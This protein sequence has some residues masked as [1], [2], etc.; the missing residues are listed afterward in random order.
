M[1]KLS[2]IIP[3]RNEGEKLEQV[4]KEVF[5]L[6]PYEVITVI[7]G[8]TDR[9]REIAEAHDC[10]VLYY[11]NPLGH[12]IGRAI[13]AYFSKGDILLFMDGDM[14]IPYQDLIPF[15]ETMEDGADIALNNLE[16]LLMEPHRPHSISI[17]KKALNE[18]YEAPELT[19]NSLV[20]IP[21]SISRDALKKIG[22]HN[23]AIPPLAQGKA[24]KEQLDIITPKYLDVI[25]LNKVRP[26]L[27]LN[28][29]T[30]TPYVPLE[31]IIIGD[32]L[33]A[34]HYLIKLKGERAGFADYRDREFINQFK[35]HKKKRQK[36]KS[37]II[38]D[39][40]NAP[41][42]Q[43]SMH[44]QRLKEADS[45]EIIV[46]TYD[47]DKEKSSALLLEGA[48]VIPLN[49]S[50][51]PCITRSIGAFYSSGEVVLFTDPLQA[52]SKEDYQMIFK[53]LDAGADIALID[54]S[55]SLDDN[56]IGLQCTMH[57][58][59]NILLSQPTLWNN[60]IYSFPHAIRRTVIN[61][62]GYDSLA[63]PPLAQTKAFM[64]HYK[65]IPIQTSV[66]KTALPDNKE[67]E[68]FIGDHVEAIAWFLSKTNERGAFSAGGKNYKAVHEL[69]K[70]TPQASSFMSMIKTFFKFNE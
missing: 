18:M 62:I 67:N 36:K 43:I 32:H 50:L 35:T 53:E 6:H 49:K 4:L 34:I 55:A 54:Q 27:H 21:H 59:L 42:T 29:S 31:N 16:G 47:E 2:V 56:P 33:S 37:A 58:L 10:V 28:I 5:M 3:V 52:F 61:D 1:S 20:A 15:I 40:N 8:S 9:S 38:C 57:Y 45:D 7:N 25:A 24:I 65:L 69:V 17:L 48:Y 60:S 41:L 13:G 64:N 63:I 11:E 44:I 19:I 30:D 23:L 68:V 46:V 39:E 22:W 14:V 66:K 12:D 51:G 70:K 26:E